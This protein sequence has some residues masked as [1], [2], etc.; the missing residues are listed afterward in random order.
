MIHCKERRHPR[1][2]VIAAR[3][4]AG[5]AK[6]GHEPVPALCDVPVVDADLGW[7]RRES[8][9]WQGG[10][11]HVE[12]LEHRQHVHVVEETA[13]PAVRE[14]EWHTI[15]GYGALV[16]EDDAV[17]CELD[18]DDENYAPSHSVQL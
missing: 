18:E 17:M 2:E 9:P 16:L 7:A 10:H 13:G 4:M 12:V 1:T 3:T 8:I 6:F 5:I 11:N 15:A 14:Y